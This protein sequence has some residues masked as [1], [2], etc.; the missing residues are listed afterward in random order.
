MHF[1]S[2]FHPVRLGICKQAIRAFPAAWYIFVMD[3]QWIP[4]CPSPMGNDL[5]L[6]MV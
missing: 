3:C 4:T 1:V 6:L 5:E 2:F